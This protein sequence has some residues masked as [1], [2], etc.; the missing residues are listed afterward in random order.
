MNAIATEIF[1]KL[2]RTEFLRRFYA[3]DLRMHDRGIT[4]TARKV[5]ERNLLHMTV[6]VTKLE[7]GAFHVSFS[8]SQTSGYEACIDPDMKV[9]LRAINAVYSNM[10]YIMEE[11]ATDEGEKGDE[12]DE[13]WRGSLYELAREDGLYDKYGVEGNA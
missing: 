5:T 8:D 12:G 10:E 9:I 6:A 3:A 1:M 2:G 11:M 7:D 4:F 13:E